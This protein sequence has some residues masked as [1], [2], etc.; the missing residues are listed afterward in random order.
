MI[1]PMDKDLTLEE[2]GLLATMINLPEADYCNI[3]FLAKLSNDSQAKI[4]NL[5]HNLISK[6]YVI[7]LNNKYVINKNKI[8]IM[9][10][11]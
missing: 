11:V 1:L 8:P 6:H 4:R 9:K 7:T 5:M 3:A 10:V 2:L